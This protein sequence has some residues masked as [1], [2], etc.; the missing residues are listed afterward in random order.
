MEIV[1]RTVIKELR[2]IEEDSG[3]DIVNEIL[4]EFLSDIT[5]EISNMGSALTANDLEKCS[6]IA[7]KMKSSSANVGAMK[8]SSLFEDIE[9]MTFEGTSEVSLVSLKFKEVE[10]TLPDTIKILKEL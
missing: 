8:L 3:Q 9:R 5:G 6:Q 4:D 2:V 7:H 10:E 1:D